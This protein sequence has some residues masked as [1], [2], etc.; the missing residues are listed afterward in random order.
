MFSIWGHKTSR[1]WPRENL[2]GVDTVPKRSV[3]TLINPSMGGP[4]ARRKIL[5]SSTGTWVLGSWGQCQVA[6][7]Q[8][9]AV[10]I[11]TGACSSLH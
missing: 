6:V 2:S 1:S 7:E 11:Y 9:L 3:E 4:E 10:F 8:L 5:V